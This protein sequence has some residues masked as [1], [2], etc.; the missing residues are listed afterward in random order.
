[1]KDLFSEETPHIAARP[2]NSHRAETPLSQ[3]YHTIFYIKV[4]GNIGGSPGRM[5]VKA[6][7]IV[8]F[9]TLDI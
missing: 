2:R 5:K 6:L 7:E 8:N 4:T 3:N 1:M 9:Q